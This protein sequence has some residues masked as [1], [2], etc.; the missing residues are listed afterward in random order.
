MHLPPHPPLAVRH[1]PPSSPPF[2]GAI[3]QVG[4]AK[5]I[6]ELKATEALGGPADADTLIATLSDELIASAPTDAEMAR[7]RRLQDTYHMGQCGYACACAF[8]SALYARTELCLRARERLTQ[9]LL[10]MGPTRLAAVKGA[11]APLVNEMLPQL[12]AELAA[13]K[14]SVVD[15]L[16]REVAVQYASVRGAK[17]VASGL[18]VAGS[19]IAFTPAAPVGVGLLMAGGGLGATAAG[20]DVMGHRWQQQEITSSLTAITEAEASVIASLGALRDDHLG[21]FPEADWE[22]ARSAGVDCEFFD[23]EVDPSLALLTAGMST[24]TMA[25]AAVS[26]G[27]SL[28]APAFGIVGATV[29]LADFAFHCVNDSPNASALDQ[30]STFLEARAQAYQVWLVLLGEFMALEAPVDDTKDDDYVDNAGDAAAIAAAIAA[31]AIAA[32]CSGDALPSDAPHGFAAAPS[33]DTAAGAVPVVSTDP[34]AMDTPDALAKEL[35]RERS[36]EFTRSMRNGLVHVFSSSPLD[37][38]SADALP[39]PTR[40]ARANVKPMRSF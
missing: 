13:C 4:V 23:G 27:V 14:S 2:V 6:F 30:L 26:K 5:H 8:T 32:V 24:A 25:S 19:V 17:A 36:A 33:P 22:A 39:V 15:R 40:A 7:L 20:G 1:A 3:W 28:L 12:L 21:E 18:S 35:E 31:A 11:C 34:T 10:A 9:R 16:K 37:M 29:S 38:P